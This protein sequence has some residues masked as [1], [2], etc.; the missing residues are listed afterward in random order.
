[1]LFTIAP[2]PSVPSAADSLSATV[3]VLAVTVTNRSPLLFL[4]Q[5]FPKVVAK[6][7]QYLPQHHTRDILMRPIMSNVAEACSQVFSLLETEYSA[8]EVA[9]FG[10]ISA[11]ELQQLFASA[12]AA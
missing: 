5:E 1:M 2:P 7:R 11:E 9:G 10:F 12:A 8:E 4:W 6:S 3:D